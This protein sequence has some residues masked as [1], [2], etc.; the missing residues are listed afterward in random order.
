MYSVK[1]VADSHLI[2]SQKSCLPV[3]LYEDAKKSN[4]TCQPLLHSSEKESGRDV[5]LALAGHLMYVDP[6][7]SDDLKSK[8]LDAA[9]REGAVIID[10]WFVGCAATYVVCEGLHI[11][12]YFGRTNNLV[13]SVAL[14]VGDWFF[15]QVGVSAIDCPYPCDNTCHN[16]VSK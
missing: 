10:H 13:T 2:S 9:S 12:R 14:S 1:S 6:D 15:Y 16:L 3:S 7:I 8:V 11:H 4:V 5:D